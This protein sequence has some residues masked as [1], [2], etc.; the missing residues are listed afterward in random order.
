MTLPWEPGPPLLALVRGWDRRAPLDLPDG[1]TPAG[2]LRWAAG[3]LDGVATHHMGVDEVGAA[4]A[5]GRLIGLLAAAARGGEE[6]K[7]AFYAALLEVRALAVADALVSALASQE[8]LQRD[9]VAPV[10][11][12]LL[13]TAAHAEPLKIGII[14]AGAAG[15]PA[16]M[17]DLVALARHDEFTLFAAIAAANLVEDPLGVWWEMARAVEGWGKV[18]VVER[19]CERVED[20]EDLKAWLLRHGCRNAVMDEYLAAP[21]ARAGG[22]AEAIGGEEADDDLL[23]GACRIVGALLNE[24]PA[25][26]LNSW[27][28]GVRAVR[29]L[30]GHLEVRCT[31][32]ARLGTVARLRA[33]VTGGD[34]SAWTDRE[35]YGWDTETRSKIAETCRDIL[36]DPGWPRRVEEVFGKGTREEQG[37]AWAVAPAVGLDLWERGIERLQRDAT[38]EWLWYGLAVRSD[39]A[40]FHRLLSLAETRLPLQET[41]SPG[42]SPPFRSHACL[43]A[44]VQEMPRIGVLSDRILE[45]ALN[46]PVAGLRSRATS[47]LGDLPAARVAESVRAALASAAEHEAEEE[48]KKRMSDIVRLWRE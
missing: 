42:P 30:L 4:E 20:R 24:G 47:V 19:L 29:G 26:S 38:E 10:A 3:A 13:D 37:E 39:S 25:E 11:R 7:S 45:C 35:P 8:D 34:E 46:S 9:D 18:H 17:P 33:W 41:P 43:A 48:L 27:E 15:S 16:E 23:D 22:L 12:W 32:V 28:D 44:L 2:G 36:A 31:T 21:C 5:A 6:G 40:R 1:L 14:L